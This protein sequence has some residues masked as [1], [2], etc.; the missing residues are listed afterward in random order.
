MK[1]KTE[2]IE[3]IKVIYMRSLGP[4]GQNNIKTMEAFKDWCIGKKL[5]NEESTVFG[6]IHDDPLTTEPEK[7]RYDVCVTI[8]EDFSVVDDR[9]AK[10][11]IMDG[12]YAVYEIIHTAEEVEK[13]WANIYREIGSG[14]IKLDLTRPIVERYES[15]MLRKH[16]CEICIP[17]F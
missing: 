1:M 13:A 4:Y 11:I 2:Y 6:V 14:M 8:D 9:V 10:G 12:N 16:R 17:T 3:P 15:Q 5:F 7:C